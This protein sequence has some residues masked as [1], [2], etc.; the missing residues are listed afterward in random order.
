MVSD[1]KKPY[2]TKVQ[3]AASVM[4]MDELPVKGHG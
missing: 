2:D 4:A 1:G 3:K